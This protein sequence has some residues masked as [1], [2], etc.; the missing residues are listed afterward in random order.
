MPIGNELVASRV[1]AALRNESLGDLEA[2][3]ADF[4]KVVSSEPSDL[5]DV[6]IDLTP[7][8]DCARRLGHDPAVVLSPI[9]ST[10]ADWLGEAFTK[11]VL[12]SDVTLGAF[13]WSLVEATDG[14]SYRFDLPSFD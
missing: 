4:V 6:M 2:A 11:F 7:F 14:L 3:F 12:R 5:R 8:L 9:A 13:G 1:S 10:G